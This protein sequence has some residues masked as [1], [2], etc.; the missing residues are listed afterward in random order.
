MT[1]KVTQIAAL[2]IASTMLVSCASK[3]KT[4]TT[5][6]TT[7]TAVTKDAK[8]TAAKTAPKTAAAVTQAGAVVCKSGSDTRTLEV[9]TKDVGCELAYTK[10]DE[11]TTKATSGNGTAHCESIKEK[12]KGNL[13]SSGFKCE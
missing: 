13:E 3:S 6:T 12:I 9:L 1:L 10:F 7:K 8:N 5:S 2:L 4:A 11:T